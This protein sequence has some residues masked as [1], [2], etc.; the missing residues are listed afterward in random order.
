VPAGLLRCVQLEPGGEFGRQVGEHGAARYAVPRAFNVRL[1]DKEEG[2][3]AVR[4]RGH[5]C[6]AVKNQR[7]R[8]HERH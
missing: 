1:R 2:V 4:D 5:G 6:N 7:H 3:D 8:G